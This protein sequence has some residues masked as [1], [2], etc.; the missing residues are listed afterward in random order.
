[1]KKPPAE[2]SLSSMRNLLSYNMRTGEFRW[3]RDRGRTAKAG[4][5]AGTRLPNGHLMITVEG[6][7]YLGTRLAWLYVTGGFPPGRLTT[8]NRDPSDLRWSNIMLESDTW[9]TSKA[10]AYQREYRRRRNFARYGDNPG[11]SGS[12]PFMDDHDPRN[13]NGAV[14][15]PATIPRK[16]KRRRIYE[17]GTGE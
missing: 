1:M 16:R 14:F 6:R 10:A 11:F 17:E 9:K 12:G 7:Q 5:P 4:D 8:S 15:D 13:P 2:L 3:K